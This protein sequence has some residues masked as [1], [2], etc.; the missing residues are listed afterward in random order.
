MFVSK[1]SSVNKSEIN[2]FNDKKYVDK[3]DSKSL[4]EDISVGNI[5]DSA[6]NTAVSNPAKPLNSTFDTM[7]NS[8]INALGN[9]AAAKLVREMHLEL[10]ADKDIFYDANKKC[11]YTWNDKKER[12]DKD[13]N[14]EIVYDTGYIKTKNGEYLTPNMEPYIVK[15][16]GNILIPVNGSAFETGKALAFI[17][18]YEETSLSKEVLSSGLQ[19]NRDLEL[20]YDKQNDVYM[21]WNSEKF[22][23]Q[24]SP[25]TEVVGEYYT[26]DNKRYK[27][28]Y[29][30]AYLS[31]SEVSEKDYQANKEGLLKI[32]DNV[33]SD[34]GSVL[35]DRTY[36]YWDK[37]MQKLV[38]FGNKADVK[39][40][41]GQNA[42]GKIQDF[43]QGNIG[44]CW[45]LSAISG[46]TQHPD[47]QLRER[48]RAELEK[49]LSVDDEN[50]VTVH[51]RGIDKKYKFSSDEINNVIKNNNH[52]SIGDKDVVAIEMA[53]ESH[54]RSLID[55][56]QPFKNYTNTFNMQLPPLNLNQ[57]MVLDGGVSYNAIHL[58]TGK[59]AH[60]V[61]PSGYDDVIRFDNKYISGKI[62]DEFLLSKLKD[63]F[64]LIGYTDKQTSDT[65]MVSLRG[66][67]DE[68]F[69]V[70]DS[71]I[72]EMEPDKKI[73]PKAIPK[74]FMYEQL[75]NVQFSDLNIDIS[76]EKS[77]PIQAKIEVDVKLH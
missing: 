29:D 39:K 72:S 60:V 46:M 38:P 7:G 66:I 20:Y 4:S 23:F 31:I 1:N 53:I 14:I 8:G 44:D 22:V 36:F 75:K 70:I 63:N 52:Y 11:Y 47:P 56:K 65:H 55:S 49:S 13:K 57:D 74:K 18:G 12:F 27:L 67:D 10:T 37:E 15:D 9:S 24:K 76:P 54:L 59:E 6:S 34:K 43:R 68:N 25:V 33:Y 48:F 28:D 35:E 69:Y 2:I 64:V 21:S 26:Q 16:T 45:L 58:L 51:L 40:M 17:K 42:D 32:N 41:I 50:N 30:G 73:K 19:D 3:P 71:N 61:T 62:D 5:F 77:K